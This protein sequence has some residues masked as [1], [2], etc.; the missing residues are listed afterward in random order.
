MEGNG[1]TPTNQQRNEDMTS[2]KGSTIKGPALFTAQGW[3]KE[4]WSNLR[5]FATSAAA[6]GYK[7]LQVHLWGN[8]P[9]DLELAAASKGYCDEQQG[10]ATGAGCPIVELAN[11]VEGQLVRCSPP[12]RPLFRGFAPEHIRRNWVAVQEWARMRMKLSASA[13]RNFGF[14][15]L[16]AFP[17]T[18]IFHTVYPWAQRPKGLREAAFHA[19]ADAW[20]PVFD[21]GDKLGVR[22]CFELHPVEDLMDGSAFNRFKKYIG[23]RG[24]AKILLDLSHRVLAAAS[25]ANMEEF[26]RN[27]LDDILMFHVKDGELIPTAESDAYGSYLD[28]SERPGRFRSTGDGQIDYQRIFNLLGRELCLALWGTVEWE[29]CAGKGWEQGVSEGAQYTTA[30]INQTEPPKQTAP[31]GPAEV[32]DD[33]AATEVDADLLAEILGIPVDQVKTDEPQ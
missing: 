5:E 14:D 32:F 19:L 20:N 10:V 28:W 7:G 21:H 9:I 17:G 25:Q 1:S 23:S 24:S 18:S 15:R 30:W 33:F 12:Y 13:A 6:R 2:A 31:S 8:D 29:D 26:I 22:Y 16:A 3:G 4:G 11:H 27:H